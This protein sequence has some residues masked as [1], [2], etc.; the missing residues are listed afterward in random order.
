VQADAPAQFFVLFAGRDGQ[1]DPVELAR[2]IATNPRWDEMPGAVLVAR[3][4]P[5]P[6]LAVVGSFDPDGERALVSLAWQLAP[7]PV[8]YVGYEQAQHDA[9]RLATVL[10]DRFGHSELHRFRFAPIPRG[11]LIVLG[12]LAYLLE[13]DQQQLEPPHPPDLPLVVVDDCSLTGS[14]FRRYLQACS[15]LQV[16]FAHLYSHPGL[17]VALQA[18]EP[19]VV[20]CLAAGDLVDHA[21]RLQRDGYSAW[22]RRWR[23]R[24]GDHYWI[25]QP[26]HLIFPW[27]EPDTG[28]WNPDVG[29]IEAGWHLAAPDRCLEVRESRPRIDV[30]VQETGPGPLRPGPQVLCAGLE[31]RIVVGDLA[32]GQSFSLAGVSAAMW[33]ALLQHGALEEALAELTQAY[34]IPPSVLRE[35]LQAFV[36]EL[37]SRGVLVIGRPGPA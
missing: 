8:R 7:G 34:D 14:R 22:Q 3:R 19:R 18:A 13:L 6:A 26:D 15:S 11:G 24:L 31:D 21:P 1:D 35:D 29:R 30:Q 12:M 25:G 5:I 32:T 2:T 27:G 16:V 9:E 23:E 33:R 37:Q 36:G 17:R 20:A 10:V 28:V 4:E